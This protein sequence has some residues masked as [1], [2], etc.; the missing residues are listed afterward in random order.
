MH[1]DHVLD[2]DDVFSYLKRVNGAVEADLYGQLLAA[3]NEYKDGDA[4]RNLAAADENSRKHARQLLGRTRISAIAKCPVFVDDLQR[5]LQ[6]SVDRNWF[7]KFSHWTFAELK[8]FLLERS[9]K[10]VQA[11]L[12]GLDSDTISLVVRLM[13]NDELCQLG[14]KIFNPLPA[15]FLGA[16]GYLGARIQPNS[17]TDNPEDIIWQVFDGWSYA[18]G[19]LML[20]TNPVSDSL[21]N[22]AAVEAALKDILDTFALSD[23]LPWCVL[24]HID[25]QAELEERFAG[26]TAIWFQS[27]AGVD[28]ANRIYNISVQKMMEYAALRSGR[29]GLYLETGQGADASNGMAKGF[30]M[31]MHESRKYGFVRALGQKITSVTGRQPWI[32]VNDVGGFIGPEVFRTKDQL[33]RVCLE[34]TV[35]GKLHGLTTGLDICATLHMDISLD[36]L[37]EAQDEIIRACPAYL[38]ALP[39]RNDPMLSYLSTGFQDHVRLRAENELRVNDAMWSFFKD[40]GIVGT[41]NSYTEHFGDP[42]WVFYQYRLKK[43]DRRTQDEIYREGEEAISRIR[44][45]GLVLARGYGKNVVELAPSIDRELRGFYATAR[46]ALWAEVSTSFI[47][48]SGF[49]PLYSHAVDRSDHIE[50]PLLGEQLRDSSQEV[51]GRLLQSWGE[52]IP[53]VQI[54][55]SDGLNSLAITD[56]G[57]LSPYLD[58][59]QEDLQTHGYSVADEILFIRYGRVRAGYQIG[60][61]L[62]AGADPDTPKAVFHIIGERPGSG[63][64]NY[65]VYIAAPKAAQW[66]AGSVDHDSVR[67]VSGISDTALLPAEAAKETVAIL[68]E[69]TG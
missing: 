49:I 4:S 67:V 37:T 40:I 15:S 44:T 21:D 5:L 19:D 28:D 36:D 6:G 59:V 45:R 35:M 53:D 8:S 65:S 63:H 3:A 7:S 23:T 31:V 43:G 2:N 26:S 51:L 17:P 54:V 32:H 48:E 11:I 24:A 1:I 50:Q 57:H 56:D 69:M 34:D 12:P 38:M 30:D 33:V 13:S 22:I 58:T 68:A 55:V 64:H 10:E 20:G 62:F 61:L 9:E 52:D 46:E 16:K 27:L 14:S 18:T 39:T 47:S 42:I 25:K 29:Y 60:S 66:T 41:D